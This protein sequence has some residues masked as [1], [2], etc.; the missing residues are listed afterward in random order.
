FGVPGFRT[1][2]LIDGN[3]VGPTGAVLTGIRFRSDRNSMPLP[4]TTIPNVTVEVGETT[5]V[6]NAMQTTFAFN[7]S[8]PMTTVFSGSVVVPGGTQG[9]AGPQPW[10]IAITFTPPVAFTTANGNLLIDIK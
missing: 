6:L 8:G 7:V 9:H 3:A 1:Q 4:G 2:I 5:A 10:D